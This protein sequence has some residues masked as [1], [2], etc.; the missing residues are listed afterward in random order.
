M[1][2]MPAHPRKIYCRN[3]NKILFVNSFARKFCSNR[4]RYLKK[5]EK[6]GQREKDQAQAKS[7][8]KRHQK[9]LR[10]YAQKYYAPY[11][12]LL[13]IPLTMYVGVQNTIGKLDNINHFTL[14]ALLQ[15]FYMFL[16]FNQIL[17]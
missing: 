9:Q 12:P 13:G 7:Y 5:R 11:I 3:C 8:A 6:P 16:I 1:K 15:G 2:G 17:S 14:S 4:C 10:V